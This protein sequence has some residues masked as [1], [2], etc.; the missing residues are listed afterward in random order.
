[1]GYG[2]DGAVTLRDEVAGDVTQEQSAGCGEVDDVGELC[3][4]EM[5]R[6]GWLVAV[7]MSKRQFADTQQQRTAELPDS[8]TDTSKRIHR[9]TYSC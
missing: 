5:W 4:I 8:Q 2:G 6:L 3:P 1:M 7:Q 9:D